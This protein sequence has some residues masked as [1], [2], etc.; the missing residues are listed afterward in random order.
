L[1]AEAAAAAF[2]LARR[3]APAGPSPATTPPSEPAK[4]VAPAPSTITLRD[5]RT[6]HLLALGDS[7]LSARIAAEIGP[8]VE[9]V[10]AFWSDDWRREITIITT[11]TDEEFQAL[12][13]GGPDIA[14]STT[15]ERIVFA[16]GAA[17]MSPGALRIV[18]RHELF[19]YAS[20][21]VTAADAPWSLTEGVADY[22]G[23]PR[24]PVPGPARAAEFSV[25]PTNADFEVTGDALAL[26]YDRSWWFARFV[27]ARFG[28]PVLRQLYLV[29]CGAGHPDLDTALT[30]T[31][32][33][34]RDTMLAAWRQW[35]SG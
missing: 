29:A 19:H 20:R 28:D 33:I 12:A 17:G 21:L 11:G 2:V 25:L 34:N 32:G 4:P 22:V 26:A 35:L 31:L 9:A 16:P 1:A 24:T 5:G 18:L 8:A 23:R 30:Q 10:T 7:A 27:G 15:V 13:G 6:V 3:P 14:A